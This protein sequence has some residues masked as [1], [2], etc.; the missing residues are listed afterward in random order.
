M[1]KKV[2]KQI[3][4][5]QREQIENL[6]KALA[7]MSMLN[8]KS[9]TMNIPIGAVPYINGTRLD[10]RLNNKR[11]TPPGLVGSIKEAEKENGQYQEIPRDIDES[12]MYPSRMRTF[13]LKPSKETQNLFKN[14]AKT[15]SFRT[16]NSSEPDGF[17]KKIYPKMSNDPSGDRDKDNAITRLEDDD[18]VYMENWNDLL[19][20]LQDADF[21]VEDEL[22]YAELSSRLVNMVPISKLVLARATMDNGDALNATIWLIETLRFMD[23]ECSDSNRCIGRDITVD[24]IRSMLVTAFKTASGD[25]I[26]IMRRALDE[27]DDSHNMSKEEN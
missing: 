23:R 9:N 12:S 5:R 17:V 14:D 3:I 2:M 8:K 20:D 1:K 27:Y 7:A 22:S 21:P 19:A 4:K 25:V 16:I 13:E 26:E 15:F 11:L 6:T 24:P 10:P 18:F